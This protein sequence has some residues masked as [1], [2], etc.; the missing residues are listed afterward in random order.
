MKILEKIKSKKKVSKNKGLTQLESEEIIRFETKNEPIESTIAEYHEI[1]YSKDVGS[2]NDISHQRENVSSEQICWRD[3]NV[4]EENV[5][6]ISK[7]RSKIPET[8]LSK[9]VDR[10][11]TRRKKKSRKPSNV[12]YVVSKPQP[13]Q[14]RGDWAVR[15]HGK[16]FSYHR[17]KENAI[18]KARDIARQRNATVLIQNTDG[19]LNGKEI[20][21]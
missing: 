4:I 11:I 15:S 3:I 18:Q 2:K 19:T 20:K 9:T 6:N 5:D 17:I 14:V 7:Q 16:I 21:E 12:I 8:E 10:I 13:G 1:L